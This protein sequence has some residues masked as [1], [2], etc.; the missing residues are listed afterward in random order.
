MNEQYGGRT[1]AVSLIAAAVMSCMLLLGTGFIQYLPIPVL[2]AIVISALMGA[3]EFHIAHRLFRA[4]RKEFYIFVGAV[5]RRAGARDDL[6]RHHRGAAVV[7]GR[8][9]PRVPAEA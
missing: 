5:S 1:Q 7:C 3:T 6:R 9:P 2:T 4:D 8:H